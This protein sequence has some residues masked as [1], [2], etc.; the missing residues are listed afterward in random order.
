M[1]QP[2][3][4]AGVGVTEGFCCTGCYSNRGRGRQ[5]SIMGEETHGQV[6]LERGLP[7]MS[8]AH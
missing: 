8:F 6:S 1:T 2:A 5:G 4:C 7:P 3:S